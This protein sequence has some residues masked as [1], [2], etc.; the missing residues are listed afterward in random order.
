MSAGAFHGR[1]ES[2]Y[3][4]QPY[5][6]S[7]TGFYFA[8]LEEY[9]TK[10]ATAVDD[11]GQPV[12]EFELQYIDG[13]HAELFRALRVSQASL[14]DWF[15]L[16]DALGSE[17]DRYLIACHLA[18]LGYAIGDLADGWDDYA[19]YRGTAADYAAEMVADCYELP[20]NIIA[21][22]DYERLGR[23]M[24]LGGDITELKYDVILI[25]G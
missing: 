21:Y 2:M 19:I 14:A 1:A 16:V 22:I 24:I 23:D 3:F 8:D 20:D 12:E 11:F 25:G 9:Q 15:E 4:A 10:A 7:A 6:L 5:N 13:D 17:E 18:D